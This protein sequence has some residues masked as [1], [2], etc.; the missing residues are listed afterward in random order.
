LLPLEQA[1][2]HPDLNHRETYLYSFVPYLDSLQT[3]VRVIIAFLYCQLE[4]ASNTIHLRPPP[5]LSD[6]KR[7]RR[8]QASVCVAPLPFPLP[9]SSSFP[10]APTDLEHG[11]LSAGRRLRQIQP[12]VGQ[13]GL[14]H[15][16]GQGFH[17]MAAAP[18]SSR[19]G[20]VLALK[21]SKVMGAALLSPPILS[22]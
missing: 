7:Q 18:C 15:V 2:I 19:F 1:P 9:P 8:S 3:S 4:A 22:S 12:H 11:F 10:H 20:G 5:P 16:G 21:A 17:A 14:L 6:N 13:I